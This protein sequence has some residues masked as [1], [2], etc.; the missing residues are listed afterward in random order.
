MNGRI[1]EHATATALDT[2][3]GISEISEFNREKETDR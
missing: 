3:T 1:L 2:N